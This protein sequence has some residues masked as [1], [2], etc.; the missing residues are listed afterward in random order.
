MS[1]RALRGT[2]LGATSYET[3][4]G[5][6]PAA[7]LI[8]S[9]DCPLG[10]VFT[11]PFSVE[12]DVPARWECR[13]CGNIATARDVPLPDEKFS[14]PQRTHWD[15]LLERRTIPQLEELL[16]ERLQLLRSG[17]TGAVPGKG[18]KKSA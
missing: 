12:A 13:Q 2:R 1:E 3:D 7:R 17:R 16:E 4:I 9:F 11:V 18:A 6:E 5:I 15:M 10:H 8:V 14:K